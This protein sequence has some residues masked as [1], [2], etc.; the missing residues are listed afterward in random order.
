M[1]V[2]SLEMRAVRCLLGMIAIAAAAACGSGD[3]GSPT[4]ERPAEPPPPPAPAD[5]G[6]DPIELHDPTEGIGEPAALDVVETVRP[7]PTRPAGR[8]RAVE[9]VLRSTP[10]GATAAVD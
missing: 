7:R 8:K 1:M 9:I 10:P 2:A 5:A 6:P 3:G 4:R